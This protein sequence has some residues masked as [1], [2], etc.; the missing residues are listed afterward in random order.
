MPCS[1]HVERPSALIK[2]PT[3]GPPQAFDAQH[4]SLGREHAV[5]RGRQATRVILRTMDYGTWEDL[6]SLEHIA[7]HAGLANG[8]KEATLGSLR[9]QCWSLWHARLGLFDPDGNPPPMPSRR[10]LTDVPGSP[11]ADA[12]RSRCRT[13]KRPAPPVKVPSPRDPRPADAGRGTRNRSCAAR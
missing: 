2:K 5:G 13:G 12:N 11:Q 4:E 9:P 6:L 8:L 3:D 1:K 10:F 7:R